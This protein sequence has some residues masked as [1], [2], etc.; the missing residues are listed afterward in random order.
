MRSLAL[1]SPRASAGGHGEAAG[2]DAGGDRAGGEA[3]L[4]DQPAALVVFPTAIDPRAGGTLD[5]Y[6]CM[7]DSRIG[8]FR[9]TPPDPG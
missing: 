4:G 7:A 2:R 1:A 6:Y 3:L 5:V 8:A 9:L